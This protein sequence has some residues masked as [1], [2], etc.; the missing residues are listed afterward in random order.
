MHGPLH[1]H[2]TADHAHLEALL[3]RAAKDPSRFDHEAFEEFRA[4]LLRHISIEEKILLPDAR[5]RRH[6][7]PLP[8]AARLRVDHGALAALL[9]PTPDAA[10]VVEIQQILRPHDVLEEEPGG[11]YD[12]CE[13]L[14]GDEVESLLDRVRVAPSVPAAKHFD[15]HGVHRSAAEALAASERSHARAS[16]MEPEP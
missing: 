14:A 16:R 15:G 12:Q 6:G 8:L 9:V 7:T 4:G 3:L 1:A 10:L 5:R 2:L 11:L 13:E